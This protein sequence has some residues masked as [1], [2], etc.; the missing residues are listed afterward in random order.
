MS[1]EK[2]AFG[3]RREWKFKIFPNAFFS[4]RPGFR[5][6]VEWRV[7]NL[8]HSPLIGAKKPESY[9][10]GSVSFSSFLLN[11]PFLAVLM[12]SFRDNSWECRLTAMQSFAPKESDV[13]LLADVIFYDKCL[14]VRLA[15]LDKFGEIKPNKYVRSKIGVLDISLKDHEGNR[16]SDHDNNVFFLS[17]D[18]RQSQAGLEKLGHETSRE[19]GGKAETDCCG[20]HYRYELRVVEGILGDF[21]KSMSM[22]IRRIR[23]KTRKRKDSSWPAK[24]SCCSGS[25]TLRKLKTRMLL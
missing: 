10:H 23:H 25:V 18:S 21:Q 20:R 7:F 24:H 6:S 5:R 4:I 16:E 3:Q 17:F 1:S 19:V 15:A 22:K 2:V 8:N 14:K 11:N 13:N 12:R 9:L